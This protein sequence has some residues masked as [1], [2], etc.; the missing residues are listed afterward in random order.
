MITISKVGPV[1]VATAPFEMKDV[2]KNAGMY[3]HPGPLACTKS[4]CK[5]CRNGI[6]K[7]W[8]TESID[9]AAEL[10]RYADDACR[11]ELEIF[12]VKCEA[13]LQASTCLSADIEVP[14]KLPLFPFQRA[15]VKFI[16]DHGGR[17]LV[18]DPMGVGKS[19]QAI[20]FLVRNPAALPALVVAPA[21][22]KVQWTREV[23]KFSGLSVSILSGTSSQRSFE[24][25]GL[26][27]F[28]GCPTDVVV[29]NYDLLRR[30]LQLL[31]QHGF[32]TL[33][34][35]E[36]SAI[37]EPKSQRSKAA[38]RLSR[39]IPNV[40]L[41]SGTPLLNR[42][43]ELWNLTQAVD[44]DVFPNFFH[45]AKRFCDAKQVQISRSGDMAWDFGGASNLGELN[46]LLRKRVMVRR[47]KEEVL[48][49]LPEKTRVIFPIALD[50]EPK[51]QAKRLAKLAKKKAELDTWREK[52]G[53]LSTADRKIYLTKH[54]ERAAEMAGMTGV[55]I[56]EIQDI[57]KAVAFAKMPGA[58][59]R[60]LEMLSEGSKI[61]VFVHHHE[62]NDEVVKQ[63]SSAG[64]KCVRVDGRDGPAER[65]KA[66]DAIQEG[67]AQVAVLGIMAA[68]MGLNLTAAQDVVI[69]E[70]PWS[71][72]SV[73]QAE[74]R[75]WRHGQQG[76]VTTYFFVAAGTIEESIA[77][78]LD[79]KR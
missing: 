32:R 69:Y 2:L 70:L 68:G 11:A 41:L 72:N 76:R 9:K 21:S 60:L 17:A 46:T 35:D 57:Q 65:Q 50:K 24:K 61:L 79:A 25:L 13:S 49:E 6:L 20:G 53:T 40:I 47:E 64:I 22:V 63:L 42:P 48:T 36:A 8:W 29:A 78:M 56:S 15:G 44:P 71:P 52:L 18:A 45:F 26:K 33:V 3:W 67:D 27:L 77:R 51:D 5:A 66:V 31:E 38:I 10:V 54:A 14:T 43:K 28:P 62:V 1:W 23:S 19:A 16:E 55:L 58:I 37:K 73:D 34:L 4:G 12:G 59:E 74:A 39:L 75:S 7:S 30:N